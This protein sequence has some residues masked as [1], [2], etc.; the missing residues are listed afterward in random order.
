MPRQ[1]IRPPE[2]VQPRRPLL[3]VALAALLS[4]LPIGTVAAQ[5]PLVTVPLDDPV[6]LV[7]DG[8]VH[9]GCQVARVSSY[10]PYFVRDVRE[11]VRRAA[12]DSSCPSTL[13]ARLQ[14]RFATDTFDI[15][16]DNEGA[17]SAGG[18]LTVRATGLSNGEFRPLWAGVRPTSE[19]DPPA[20]AIAAGR[21]TWGARNLV[22]VAEARGYTHRRN[23]P[24]VHQRG[25]RST[26]GALD[27]GDSYLN[28]RLGKSLT[29]SFGRAE[30]AWL[31]EGRE[32][33]A[34]SA[35]GP[36]I[37]RLL[38]YGRWRRVEGRAL[39][40]MLSSVAMTPQLDSVA[41][42]HQFYRYL[43]GHALTIRP[44]RALEINLGETALLARGTQTLDLAY[45][46]PFMAYVVTQNDTSRYG[47][48]AGDNLQIFGGARVASG[49]SAVEGELLVDDIQIDP[50]DRKKTQDQLA[51]RVRGTQRLP[52]WVPASASAEYRRIDSYTYRRS[53]YAT[54]YQNYDAPLGS[55][56]GPDAD[57]WRLG[58]ELWLTGAASL[59]GGVSGWRQG[60]Q[61]LTARPSQNSNNH[62]G[63]PFPSVTPA[64]PAVQQALLGDAAVQYAAHPL[65][66]VLRVEGARV[67]APQNVTAV[68][69]SYLRLQ[70]I[71]RYAYSLP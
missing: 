20:S 19:G 44:T 49:G 32:S 62:A 16:S 61:R 38:V 35:W 11:V 40:G 63:E 1:K 14:Q 8:L 64:R 29:V 13:V 37:D 30:E 53:F 45:A 24:S 10:R 51:F 5:H 42:A 17:L 9:S 27:F 50:K 69:A 26:S 6:Y 67:T 31:G 52:L 39:Y 59:T 25:L 65:S 55:E 34:L 23:D 48:G 71:G 56:L 22:A 4:L 12:S 46:N 43:V 41:T 3:L 66:L 68:T 47:T 58:G 60:A 57:L 18:A 28:G 15:F 7:L 21:V 54:G 2:V 33:L 70:L 36:S